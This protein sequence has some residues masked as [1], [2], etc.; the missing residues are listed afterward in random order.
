MINF[1]KAPANGRGDKLNSDHTDA[2]ARAAFEA[3]RGALAQVGVLMLREGRETEYRK[4]GRTLEY[5]LY[6][7]TDYGSYSDV[8]DLRMTDVPTFNG[9]LEAFGYDEGAE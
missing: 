1:K 7:G 5:R 3:F 2:A 9:L 8:T 6:G 4:R